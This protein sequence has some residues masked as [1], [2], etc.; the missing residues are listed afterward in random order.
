MKVYIKEDSRLF[1]ASV[2]QIQLC[3]AQNIG[4]L[5]NIFGLTERLTERKDGKTF[6]SANIYTNKG[7]YIQVMPCAE[8]GNFCFFYLR[9]P[10]KVWEK[11]ASVLKSPFSV[12]FWYDVDKV[13]SSPAKRNREAVQ[14]QIMTVL[15][16]FHLRGVTY[17]LEYIYE[18]PQNVF[19]DFDY[20]HKVNQFLMHPYGGLRIDGELRVNV[21]CLKAM[22]GDFNNDFNFD[23][24]VDKLA[25]YLR[26]D[27]NLEFD[28]DLI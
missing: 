2:A 21:P 19:K 14:E 1:D 13:S 22:F 8:L 4:W 26:G 27:Y 15:G 9:D 24:N 18:Q 25:Q 5:D 28:I 10:Q 11:S 12:V 17:S 3:L 7:R 6:T 23:F 20:D 16:Q